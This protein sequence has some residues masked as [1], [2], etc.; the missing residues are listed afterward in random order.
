M[1][2]FNLEGYVSHKGFYL[3]FYWVIII[4]YS[5]HENQEMAIGLVNEW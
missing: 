5:Y 4:S 3:N 2:V 1:F